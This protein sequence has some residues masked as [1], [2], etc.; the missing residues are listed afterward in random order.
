[1]PEAKRPNVKVQIT[2]FP[3]KVPAIIA[4][5]YGWPMGKNTV[6]VVSADDAD[7]L[8]RESI[9]EVRN[10]RTQK[11]ESRSRF[12][13]ARLGESTMAADE[14]LPNR[15]GV[16]DAPA[17][18]IPH[19]EQTKALLQNLSA[20]QETNKLMVDLLKTVVPTKK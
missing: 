4:S 8:E 20:T 18:S 9:R 5:G 14:K 7:D 6:K 10:A 17:L 13:F 15:R 3:Q 11:I 16:A 12:S 19:E 2:P 1:M